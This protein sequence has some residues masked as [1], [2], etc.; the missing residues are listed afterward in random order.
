MLQVVT[1]WGS[2]LTIRT[3]IVIDVE[4]LR[5]GDR[6]SNSIFFCMGRKSLAPDDDMLVL[7]K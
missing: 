7:K 6:K 3:I 5:R 2:Q 4:I 1:S